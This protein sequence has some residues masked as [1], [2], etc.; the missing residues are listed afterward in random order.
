MAENSPYKKL[1][2]EEFPPVSTE[3]WESLVKEDLKGKDFR[4]ELLWQSPDDFEALPFYRRDDLDSLSHTP[5]PIIHSA[6]WEIVERIDISEIKFANAH[7]ISALEN[8]AS[9]LIFD[10]PANS[11][12][13]KQ[14]L[15]HLLENIQPEMIS[16][17]FEKQLCQEEIIRWLVEWTS[18]QDLNMGELKIFFNAEPFSEALLTGKLASKENIA[19]KLRSVQHIK[20][21]AVDAACYANAGANIVQQLAFAL[22]AGNEY[23]NLQDELQ[24]DLNELSSGMHFNFATASSFFPEISKYRAFR[25]LWSQIL[26]AYE[27]DLSKFTPLHMMAGTASWNKPRMDAYNNMIRSTTEAMSA[28]LGGCNYILVERFDKNWAPHSEFA[29]R[30]ARNTQHILQHEVYLNKVADAGAG[31]YYIEKLTDDIAIQSWKLFQEIEKTGGFHEAIKEG[32]IQKLIA[33]SRDK[34][35]QAYRSKEEIIVGVNKY[36][37]DEE[38]QSNNKRQFEPGNFFKGEEDVEKVNIFNIEDEIASGGEA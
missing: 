31:S 30:I 34:K 24:R 14:D 33:E 23:L 21:Y 18:G 12:Q 15:E 26:D 8:G 5:D 38:K 11:I 22:A 17:H 13:Q 32:M 29:S 27:D 35:I 9:G 6:D 36:P 19:E 16:L 10:L 3:E 25:L 1:T 28:A 20:S 7:A 2:F 37:P 4:S